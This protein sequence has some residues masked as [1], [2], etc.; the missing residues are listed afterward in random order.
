MRACGLGDDPAAAILDGGA[1]ALSS[2]PPFGIQGRGFAR[3]N[4]GTSPALVEE[5]VE[6]LARVVQ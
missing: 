5:I 2:G 1:L 4:F 3:L 6:R